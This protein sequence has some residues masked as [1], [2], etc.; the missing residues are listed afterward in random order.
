MVHPHAIPNLLACEAFEFCT[1]LL[2]E[3]LFHVLDDVVIVQAKRV[4][5][6]GVIRTFTIYTISVYGELYG[7]L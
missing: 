1:Q 3:D 2:R 5:V 7:T 4:Q 6:N